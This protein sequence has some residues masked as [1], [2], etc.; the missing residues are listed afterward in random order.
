MHF[1]SSFFARDWPPRYILKLF[2]DSYSL[3]EEVR[4]GT[5]V[6]FTSIGTNRCE[7][8][9]K[10]SNLAMHCNPCHRSTERFPYSVVPLRWALFIACYGFVQYIAN[11]MKLEHSP[12]WIE[13]LQTDFETCWLDFLPSTTARA[14]C[15]ND[16]LI[17]GFP[18][19]LGSFPNPPI[20]V[21]GTLK[22]WDECQGHQL[23]RP[24]PRPANQK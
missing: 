6:H 21:S 8:L 3:T 5:N 9:E 19:W 22:L 11:R 24:R 18:R 23:P 15:L 20:F 10:Q 14:P 12:L 1:S 17:S 13:P 16:W 4:T 2:S 7:E